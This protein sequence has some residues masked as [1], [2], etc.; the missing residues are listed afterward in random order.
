[1]QAELGDDPLNAAG[2]DGVAGLANFLGQDAGGSFRVEKAV[3]NDLLA[4]LLG[5]AVSGFGAAFVA[6][7]SQGAPLLEEM[8]QLIVTLL[9]EAELAGGGQ[10]AGLLALAFVEHGEFA[11]DFVIVGHEQGAGGSAEDQAWRIGREFNHEESVRHWGIKSNQIWHYFRT[12]S[13]WD[14]EL[15]QHPWVLR[16]FGGG[17]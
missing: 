9:A 8:E 3:T 7:Q 15:I 1:L 13:A 10:G 16:R 4:G 12:K 17:G 11:G 2:A 6:E 5:T 14:W